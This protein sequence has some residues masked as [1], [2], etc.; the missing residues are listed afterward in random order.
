MIIG[1]TSISVK[2]DTGGDCCVMTLNTYNTISARPK[3]VPTDA[4]IRVGGMIIMVKLVGEAVFSVA[5]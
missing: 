5:F 1:N 3:V 4:L 2:L